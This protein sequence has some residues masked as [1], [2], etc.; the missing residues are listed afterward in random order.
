MAGFDLVARLKL[1][2]QFSNRMQKATRQMSRA[3]KA[4]KGLTSGFSR[5]SS[6]VA[7]IGTAIGVTAAVA[8]GFNM[9]R[10]SV[11]SAFKRI[12]TM[13]SFERT[14]TTLTGSAEKTAEALESTREAVTGTAY[15]LDVAAKG[16]QD[17]VTRGMDIEKATGTMAAWG[18]AVAF[19]GD[20]SNEQLSSVSDALAKM[21]SSGKV[22]MDQMNRLY[23]AGIDGVGMYAKAVGRDVAS[24]QKDLSSGA[25]GADEFIDVVGTAMMEGTNGVTKIAGAAKE[26]G[27]SWG[28]SFDNMRAAVTRGVVN[29]I[30]G[31]DDMLTDNG[32]PDMRTMVANFGKQFEST[33]NKAAEQIPKVVSHVQSFYNAIKPVLPY[34][35]NVALALAGVFAFTSAFSKIAAGVTFLASPLGLVIAGVMGL[36]MAFQLA[37]EKSETFRNIVDKIV[38]T[39]KGLFTGETSGADLLAMLG[40]TP[41]QI[42][43][44]KGFIDNVITA[45]VGLKDQ[46]VE[47]LSTLYQAAQ[48]I[49]AQ[50]GNVF[51]ILADI[52]TMVFNN[53]IVPAVSFLWQAFQ[54]A[55]KI[56]GPILELLGAAIGTAFAVLKVVWDTILK[57]VA[58]FLL[59]QFAEALNS[60]KPILDIVG[61][62]FDWVGDKISGVVSWLKKAADWFKSIKV[63]DWVSKI[64][65]KVGEVASAVFGSG[66]SGGTPNRYYHGIDYVPSTQNAIIHKGEAVL[67][68]QE[69]KERKQGGRGDV[70]INMNGVTIREE[71]DVDKFAYKLARL[72]EQEGAQMA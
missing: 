67:T 51:S 48:P 69:N 43:R 40:L 5:F 14:M 46:F 37:Y 13:E 68:A 52:A 2:D 30:E 10:N 44:I 23:D 72:I 27:A 62:A 12:D 3:E 64:G 29:I 9:I 54:T 24:V 36:V 45:A 65:S 71:A 21:Y 57:P 66:D 19:Y 60:V 32:L 16:V 56:I 41:E 28:A 11:D 17:F 6:Q 18:D 42:E 58:S 25:I 38:S 47:V 39:V 61:G 26:A 34:L 1:D 49:F 33:L 22:Q 8:G 4:T 31:I 50:L 15:G 7:G 59:G 55:W 53:V 63:P 20:G 35:R 70:I